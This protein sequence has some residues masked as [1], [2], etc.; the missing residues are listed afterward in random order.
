[1]F[2]F[3]FFVAPGNDPV[4]FGMPDC[5]RLQ[6]LSISCHTTNDKQKRRQINKQ[7]RCDKSKTNKN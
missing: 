1:M 2:Q 4:L 3:S 5:K 6:L 7:I